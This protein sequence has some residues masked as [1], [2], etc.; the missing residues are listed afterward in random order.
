M[1][2]MGGETTIFGYSRPPVIFDGNL[3]AAG[4]DHRLD[5]DHQTGRKPPAFP[6]VSV[7]RDVGLLV[8]GPA[9]AVPHELPDHGIAAL[10]D[11]GLDRPTDVPQPVPRNA[12]GD[13]PV[14]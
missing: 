14:E 10:F 7:V 11:V 3:R 6:G 13:G 1:L 2:K 4:V 9:D 5:G 8:H 12:G